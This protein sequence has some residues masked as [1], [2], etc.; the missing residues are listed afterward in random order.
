[1]DGNISKLKIELKHKIYSQHI[2][3]PVLLINKLK[4]YKLLELI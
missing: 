3:I 1:M 4:I 2:L